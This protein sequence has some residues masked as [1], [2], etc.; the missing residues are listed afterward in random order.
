[1]SD[2][3]DEKRFTRLCNQ[4]ERECGHLSLISRWNEHPAFTK[5]VKLAPYVWPLLFKRMWENRAHHL[6]GI[7]CTHY[8]D[9]RP[10][11][12]EYRGQVPIMVAFWCQWAREKGIA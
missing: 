11:P 4:W 10:V 2:L 5:L 12:D 8:P 1:M 6:I 9:A 3:I 7:V